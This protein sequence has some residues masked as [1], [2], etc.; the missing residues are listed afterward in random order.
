VLGPGPHGDR[1]EILYV[2]ADVF[3]LYTRRLP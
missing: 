3:P 2:L 1:Y